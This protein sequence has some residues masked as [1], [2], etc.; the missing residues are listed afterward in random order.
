MASA[1]STPA[2]PPPTTVSDVTLPARARAS[3]PT[4]PFNSAPNRRT[5]IAWRTTPRASPRAGR[6]RHAG[7]ALAEGGARAPRQ[8]R[9]IERA[10]IERVVARDDAGDHARVDEARIG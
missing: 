9:E 3:T 5:T 7:A 8:P 6:A 1:S 4:Q 2:A 10:F